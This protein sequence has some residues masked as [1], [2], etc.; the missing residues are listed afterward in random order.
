MNV[1]N[2][3]GSLLLLLMAIGSAPKEIWRTVGMERVGLLSKVRSIKVSPFDDKTQFV[4]T[5]KIRWETNIGCMDNLFK[6]AFMGK[7]EKDV[8][9]DRITIYRLEED[10]VY[11]AVLKELGE[12]RKEIALT[13]FF[14]LLKKQSQGQSGPLLTNGHGNVIFIKGNDGNFWAISAN[15]NYVDRCWGVFANSIDTPGYLFAKRQIIS[16]D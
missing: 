4:V 5:E 8:S 12:E 1:K 10:A 3:I 7:V 2:V 13:H 11:R 6:Q 16:Y 9:Q 15:W 14:A